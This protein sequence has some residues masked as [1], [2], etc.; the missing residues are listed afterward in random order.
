MTSDDRYAFV[1][2]EGIGGQPGIVE[3]IDLST[4]ER[5]A[6]AEVGKQAGGITLVPGAS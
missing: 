6:V 5:A 3:V 4:Y 1:T 2:V